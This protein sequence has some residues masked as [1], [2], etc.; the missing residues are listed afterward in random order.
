MAFVEEELAEF[1]VIE[2]VVQ[3]DYLEYENQGYYQ[4]QYE[5]Y[6]IVD[7]GDYPGQEY[8]ESYDEAIEGEEDLEEFDMTQGAP[9]EEY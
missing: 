3:D 2:C 6:E 5:E 4:D 9:L 1:N 8:M 7:P